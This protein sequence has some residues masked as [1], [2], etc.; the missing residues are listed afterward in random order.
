MDFP[1]KTPI[2]IFAKYCSRWLPY[3]KISFRKCI[4]QSQVHFWNFNFYGTYVII[5]WQLWIRK[6]SFW[7]KRCPEKIIKCQWMSTRW[8]IGNMLVLFQKRNETFFNHIVGF[9]GSRNQSKI[10]TMIKYELI[11]NWSKAGM[12]LGQEQTI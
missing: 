4:L 9:F 11:L 6:L 10:S 7:I 3:N 2:Y 8:N 5:I 12:V 1:F